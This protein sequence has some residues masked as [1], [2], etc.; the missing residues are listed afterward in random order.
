[1]HFAHS[2]TLATSFATAIL[3]TFTAVADAQVV[4]SETRIDQP[5]ADTDE[6]FELSG[7]ANTS[8]NGLTHIVIGDGATGSGTIESV[9]SLDGQSLSADGFFVAAESTFTLGTADLIATL[10]FENSDNVT[11]VLVSGFT[12]AIG[13]DLDTNDDGVLDVLPWTSVLDAVSL[14]ETPGS[15][16]AFYA[17]QL[18]GQNVG[19]DGT[20]VPAYVCRDGADF[21]IGAFDP[22][23]G[24]DTPGSENSCFEPPDPEPVAALIHEV[25]GAGSSV[26][27]TLR[28]VTQ[29]SC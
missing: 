18:G 23:G 21:V 3:M 11:H 17:S 8:L 5:G 25:Q 2:R 12:G 6:Y 13:D 24:N 29:D 28:S 10:G 9:V 20:F 4:I 7:P 27:I 14:V 15:G 19:P 26:A 16:D 22:I 1:M